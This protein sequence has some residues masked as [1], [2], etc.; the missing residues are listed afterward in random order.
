MKCL[1]FN[2]RCW[3]NPN[4][5]GAEKYLYE[6]SRRFVRKGHQVTWFVSNFD[7]GL[8]HESVDGIEILRAG[9]KFS[10]YLYAFWHY[11]LALRKGPFDV[12]IDD[13]NGVP[14]FVPLYVWGP[15]KFAV[16]HHL[17]GWKI[18]SKELKMHQAILAWFAEACITVIYSQTPVVTVSNSSKIELEHRFIKNVN[19]IQNGIDIS[20]KDYGSVRKAKNATI[21]YLGRWK[22]YKRTDLLLESFKIVKREI[23]NAELWLAGNEEKVN[24]IGFN[25]IVDFGK[26]SEDK[27]VELLSKAWVYV[28]PSNKE[29]WGITVIEAN[30]CGTCCIAYD[31]PGLRDSIVDGKTGILVKEDGD[32]ERLAHA[33]ID[34]LKDEKLRGYF[35]KN[36]L[37]WARLF[38][39]DNSADKFEKLVSSPNQL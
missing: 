34:I 38:S 39:W 21:I 12:V 23:P 20:I 17:V 25:G 8:P 14:F 32:I 29:G 18:F 13:V 5:G 11:L 31:V 28:T 10:V 2:W 33:I 6:I 27:K 24:R 19:I 15:R 7:K 30:A 1:I 37:D 26:V 9:G 3:K 16:I 36:C 35:E 4:A 22:K